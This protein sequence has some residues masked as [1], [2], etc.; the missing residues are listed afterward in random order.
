[1]RTKSN[2][3]TNM[4]KEIEKS[5]LA[6]YCP[7]CRA[8]IY[9]QEGLTREEAQKKFIQIMSENDKCPQCNRQ[10]VGEWKHAKLANKY[11]A[12]HPYYESK[13]D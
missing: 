10:Y 12:A 4:N 3:E 6:I 9:F 1:M 2:D 5:K 8:M 7:E 11:D 13:I